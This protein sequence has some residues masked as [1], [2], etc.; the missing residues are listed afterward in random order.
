MIGAQQ[1]GG[2]GIGEKPGCAIGGYIG[3]GWYRGKLAGGNIGYGTGGRM[4]CV[5]ADRDEEAAGT[6]ELV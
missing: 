1:G 5:P 2:G 6:L 4:G 3:Y